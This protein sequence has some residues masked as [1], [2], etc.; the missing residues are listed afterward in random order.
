[1]LTKLLLTLFI[2]IAVILAYDALRMYFL[3]R[4]TLAIESQTTAFSRSTG[5]GM[6][7]LVLGDSTAVG[8]G[9]ARAEDSTAG[10]LAAKYPDAEVVNLA[11]NGMKIDGLLKTMTMGP[12]VGPYDI[13]L[14]QIGANDIIRLTP[15]K[16]FE[17]GIRSVLEQSRQL[18]GPDGKVIVLHSGDIG[19]AKFFPWYVRP[20]LSKRSRSVRELYMKS[21]PGYGASYVDLFNLPQNHYASDLLHLTGEG[22]GL[23]FDEINKKL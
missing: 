14:V 21:A 19:E 5:S 16:K 11:E 13:V 10:R 20:L 22:Y 18:A 1:M 15:M 2:L 12:I 7:I 23:W 9:S 4:K 6:R 8:T 3:F 17:T